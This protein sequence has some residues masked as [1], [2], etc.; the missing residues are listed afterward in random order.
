MKI[1]AKLL[2]LGV[3]FLMGVPLFSQNV[4]LE[5]N[6]NNRTAQNMMRPARPPST[7]EMIRVIEQAANDNNISGIIL[8]ISG[9]NAGQEVL[10]ELRSALERFR[11]TGKKICVFI[12]SG[13]LDLYALATV[14]DKIVMDEQGTLTLAGYSWGRG[15][16]QHSLEK[17]GVGVRELRFMEYK[18]A[19]ET[20]TRD[21]LSD[22][23]RRQYGE[24]L[25]DIMTLTRDTITKARSWTEE[26]F[27]S[28]LN[29]FLF[30]SRSALERGLVDRVGRRDAVLDAIKELSGGREIRNFVVWG[31]RET[32]L[33]RSQNFYSPARARGL[34]PPTIAV[35]NANGTIDMDQGIAARR[36]ANTI[37]E[38]SKNRRVKAIVLRINSPGGSAEAA[39]YIA[40]AIKTARER[41]PVVVSM[42]GVAASGGYWAGI[43]A[44]H[45]VATPVTITGSI[46][47]IST[48]FFDNGLNNRLGLNVDF[49]QRGNH[50]DLFTGVILPHRDMNEREEA[51]FREYILD[52][53]NVF[54]ARVAE[55]R[56]K[57]I[58]Q[59]E[60]LAQGRVFSG[61]GAYNAGLIDGIGGLSDAIRIARDLAN[62][63]ADRQVAFIE[64]PRPRFMDRMLER[65]LSSQIV[66]RNVGFFIG[67]H[68]GTAAFVRD[69][70]LPAPLLEDVRFRITHNGKAMPLLPLG[71]RNFSR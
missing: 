14:G 52:L 64:Y 5:L 1:N 42:G 49:M 6:L 45:V 38:A 53:Y 26:K 68:G 23:D 19:A 39:D 4:F 47:V 8:N 32:S 46:G 27:E 28:V 65:V 62:I 31:N 63:P 48:W 58:E 66:A 17:L 30:S 40:E 21:T 57:S 12:S 56:N 3:L 36:L 15:F 33:T 59:V 60:S 34:R 43:T 35:I 24:I 22:A 10:W 37:R 41:V 70:F 11:A 2:A 16:V 7:L 18:S 55:H 69:L 9:F 71:S 13:N 44:N 50:A 25:D 51:R 67:S 29:D 61:I 54:V 20:F